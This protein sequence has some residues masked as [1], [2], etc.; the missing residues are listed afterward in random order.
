MT[1]SDRVVASHKSDFGVWTT[2]E[3]VCEVCGDLDK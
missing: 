1:K 3:T 2:Y